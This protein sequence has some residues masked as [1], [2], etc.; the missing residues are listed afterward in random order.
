MF[1]QRQVKDMAKLNNTRK[2]PDVVGMVEKDERNGASMP[3]V[4]FDKWC[5]GCGI[6]VEFC[7]KKVLDLDNVKGKAVV[8]RPEGCIQ[9]GQCE[10][11]CPDFAITR[12][13]KENSNG[14]KNS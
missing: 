2:K 8:A 11:R 6:C 5:K 1:G 9:C 3:V 12:V 7:P 4:V 13:K 10:L 14:K